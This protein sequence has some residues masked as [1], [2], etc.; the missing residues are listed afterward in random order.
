MTKLTIRNLMNSP[1]DLEGGVH[2]P[3]MGE[4]SG[5]FSEEYAAALRVAPGVEILEGAATDPLDH[6]G[7]GKKG[8]MKGR[9]PKADPK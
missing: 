1:Y 8:G 9:K 4:A 3:A 5:D 6:D 2:L 7:D